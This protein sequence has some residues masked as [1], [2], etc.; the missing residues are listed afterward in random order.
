MLRGVWCPCQV[1]VGEGEQPLELN[2]RRQEEA[3]AID[4]ELYDDYGFSQEQL[5]ELMGL[6]CAHAIAKVYP[7]SS[8]PRKQRTVLVACGP[9][10]NG[11]CGLVCA[12]HLKMFEFEPSIYY[13]KR[14]CRPL[15]QALTTQCEKLDIPFL[16][17]LPMEVQ[18]IN[19]AYFFVVDAIFGSGFTG[20]VLE[21]FVNVINT[22]QQ[23]R[24]PIISI[25]IPSGWPVDNFPVDGLSPT[26][27]V[28]LGAPKVCSQHFSGK[29]HFVA[30]RY[31]PP[32][33]LRK[34]E[35]NLPDYP[36]VDC[37]VSVL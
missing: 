3:R 29:Y 9:G 32:D 25:D 6:A 33:I 23:L 27:L 4:Q 19:D 17:Y 12:R 34:Y 36:N 30:G 14:P 22:L 2:P 26:V 5:V 10:K 16:S 1:R 7:V 11:A 15:C 28:S 37:V 21:P 8:L 35:L 18:L 13:P 20:Q 24:T 31:L